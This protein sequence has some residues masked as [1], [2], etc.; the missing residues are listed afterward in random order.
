VPVER[1]VAELCCVLQGRHRGPGDKTPPPM[2][3]ALLLAPF[4]ERH[5]TR[6]STKGQG[7]DRPAAV[8]HGRQSSQLHDDPAVALALVT[9][10]S[11]QDEGTGW[12]SEGRRSCAPAAPSRLDCRG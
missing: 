1:P 6:T 11:S 7:P 3:G 10:V 4:R 2:K 9:S 8:V 5:A 12:T